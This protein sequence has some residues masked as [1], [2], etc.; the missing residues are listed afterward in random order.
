MKSKCHH[1]EELYALEN[2]VKSGN[3]TIYDGYWNT[4]RWYWCL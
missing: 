1:I 4:S 2:G 3:D